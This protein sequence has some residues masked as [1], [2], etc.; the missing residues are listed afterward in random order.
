MMRLLLVEW[1]VAEGIIF[2]RA[3]Q[4]EH[5]VPMPGQ[6]LAASGVFVLL[7]L[8][9]EASPGAAQLAATLGGGFVMAAG[10]NL[11]AKIGNAAASSSKPTKPVGNR[12]GGQVA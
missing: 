7:A 4:K 2:Y 3:V 8:M 6:L 9:A 10:L 11:F 12:P 5:H 1:L